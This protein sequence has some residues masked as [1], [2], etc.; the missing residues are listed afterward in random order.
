MNKPKTEYYKTRDDGQMI[1]VTR[2]TNG[3]YL[4]QIETGSL[5]DEAFD[6]GYIGEDAQFHP[7]YFNYVETTTPIK[8]P[9]FEEPILNN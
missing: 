4:L 2:P 1:V 7:T 5:I 3:C 8:I 6:V 9:T